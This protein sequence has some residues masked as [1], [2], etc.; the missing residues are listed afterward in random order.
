MPSFF[1][2]FFAMLML[3]LDYLRFF[4]F[5]TPLIASRYFDFAILHASIF[6]QIFFFHCRYATITAI[7]DAAIL[8]CCHFDGH[9]FFFC[10]RHAIV[11]ASVFFSPLIS[12]YATRGC[13]FCKFSLFHVYAAY[14]FAIMLRLPPFSLI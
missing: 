2:F 14:A 12:D 3:L 5:H 7:A 13:F 9:T 8:R 4:I 1:F 11:Y 6:C 10:I